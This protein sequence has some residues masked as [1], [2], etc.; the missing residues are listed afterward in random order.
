MPD[1]PLSG[2]QLRLLRPVPLRPCSRGSP[3]PEPL[4]VPGRR[5][6]RD[7]AVRLGIP[8]EP[9]PQHL[10][11]ARAEDDGPGAV[12]VLGLVAQRMVEPD[13]AA[14]IDLVRPDGDD[15]LRPGAAKVL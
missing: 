5:L 8:V 14:G 11:G 15:L 13:F 10:P 3:T 6:F 2:G 9:G 7:E 12:E 4:V 1:I